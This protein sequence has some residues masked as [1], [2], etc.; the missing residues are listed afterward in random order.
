MVGSALSLNT[1][2]NLF[3]GAAHS[4][5]HSIGWPPREKPC[6]VC[7]RVSTSF[8]HVSNDDK[9]LV[10]TGCADCWVEVQAS[11]PPGIEY[12]RLRDEMCEMLLS[13]ADVLEAISPECPMVRRIRALVQK[14]HQKYADESLASLAT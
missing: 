7:H 9:V 4:N 8:V 11:F 3:T 1:H 5:V 2:S 10:W 6:P 12:L 14:V 13:S